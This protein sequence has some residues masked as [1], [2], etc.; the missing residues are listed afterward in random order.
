MPTLSYLAHETSLAVLI[1]NELAG[2]VKEA[3]TSIAVPASTRTFVTG[4]G[5][6]VVKADDKG[7]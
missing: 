2:L 1:H 7:R 3:V 4:N 6:R 5:G